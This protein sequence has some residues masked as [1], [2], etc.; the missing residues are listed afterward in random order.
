MPS[1]SAML[2]LRRRSQSFILDRL[3]HDPSASLPVLT[4]A[5]S[6]HP[7]ES[8]MQAAVSGSVLAMAVVD[9][10]AFRFPVTCA[11]I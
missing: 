2:R 9:A 7:D 10:W 5:Y 3:A 4:L 6:L 8:L 1:Q 11:E